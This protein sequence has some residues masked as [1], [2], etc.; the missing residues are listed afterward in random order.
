MALRKIDEHY[1][2]VGECFV[3]GALNARYPC[4]RCGLGIQ[5]AEPVETETI[6]IW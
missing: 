6:E 2:V 3:Y 1:V 4:P 5:C